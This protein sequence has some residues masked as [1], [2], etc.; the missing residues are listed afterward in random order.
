LAG[1]VIRSTLLRGP[2]APFVLELPPY[3]LPTVKGL[4]IHA[5]ERTWMY[6]KKAGTV[7][8]SIA[9]LLWALMTFPNLPADKV[10][11]YEDQQAKL[12]ADFLSKP[13]AQ[14]TFKSEADIEAFEKFQK[15]FKKGGSEDLQ[16][17]NPAFFN[18]AGALEADTKNKGSEKDE[19]GS[20]AENLL[21]KSYAKYR[22]EKEETENAQ[23]AAKLENTIAGRLGVAL[24][25]VF[26]PME[27]DWKTNIALVG[28]W[29]AKEVIVS[30][31]GTAYSMGEVNTKEASNLSEKLKEEP[32]WN[33][34]KAFTLLI[35]VMLYAPCLT[36]VVVM[37]KETGA[38]KWPLF[39]MAYTTILAYF[40][41][42]LVNA[43]G[44]FLGLG[45][46]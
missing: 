42:L 6:I 2:S 29:A 41:A 35:F 32:G 5:W 39:A 19:S 1:R 40:I 7:I 15:E 12:A 8:L 14:E 26:A 28:G 13:E 46:S 11:L 31:L 36:T 24:E 4:L 20:T 34:L 43:L 44:R 25:S 23:Q 38:W 9:I 18:L 37:K 21:A 3:R 30:T 33:P 45:I 16:K 27:F 17:Q 22:S 10:K